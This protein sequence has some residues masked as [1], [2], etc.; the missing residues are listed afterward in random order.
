MT[1]PRA[2]HHATDRGVRQGARGRVAPQALA[3][4]LALDGFIQPP[5]FIAYVE[6]EFDHHAL[7]FSRLGLRLSERSDLSQNVG[8]SIHDAITLHHAFSSLGSR[9]GF[10][11]REFLRHGEPAVHHE[12]R[13]GQGHGSLLNRGP[14]HADYG[15]TLYP[16]AGGG[17]FSGVSGDTRERGA[18]AQTGGHRGVD[19]RVQLEPHWAVKGPVKGCYGWRKGRRFSGRRRRG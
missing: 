3:L 4:S 10:P 16:G 14:R 1:E 15:T 9:W 19:H 17:G 18:R 11:Q 8:A 13:I 6:Q 5:E 2:Q 7:G 12:R